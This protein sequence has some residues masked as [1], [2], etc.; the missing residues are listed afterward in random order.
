MS[1]APNRPA[2]IYDTYNNVIQ[3]SFLDLAYQG[4]L[5]GGANLVYIAFARPGAAT[6]DAVWQ[7][8]KVAYSGNMPVS[9]TWPQNTSGNPSN[10]Y[11]FVYDD[12]ASYTYG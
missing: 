11:A 7:I 10:D 8:R 5:N 2:A 1:V 6:S 9:V 12:R 3:D 4:D